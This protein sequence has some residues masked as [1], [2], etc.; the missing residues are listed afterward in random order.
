MVPKFI[1]LSVIPLIFFNSI[2]LIFL[3]YLNF[4]RPLLFLNFKYLSGYQV[5]S[6]TRF[7]LCVIDYQS[8][9]FH[10][11]VRFVSST[12]F[13]ILSLSFLFISNFLS[14]TFNVIQ[15]LIINLAQVVRVEIH[16]PLLPH[17]RPILLNP[18]LCFSFPF[19]HLLLRLL[20]PIQ[21]RLPVPL[22][23]LHPIHVP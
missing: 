11:Q 3:K 10:C 1:Y 8:V 14:I 21:H 4:L 16:P 22:L 19:H 15:F 17:L 20:S 6:L 7:V 18:S 23:S 13:I 12:H 5:G 2:L 9:L